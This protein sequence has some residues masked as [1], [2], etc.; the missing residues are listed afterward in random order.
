[1]STSKEQLDKPLIS[2]TD[3]VKVGEIKDLF[4]DTDIS[5]VIAVYLGQ[6][7]NL[8]NKTDQGLERSYIQ[9]YGIDSW[10]IAG[11][12]KVRELSEI[13]GSEE[14]VQISEIRGRE[15]RSEGNTPLGIIDDVLLDK[16][17][18]VIGFSLSKVFVK[19]PLSERNAIAREAI[20]NFGS[21]DIPM[22]TLLTKA[23]LIEI[24]A[25]SIY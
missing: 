24:S 20:T 1:M 25:L 9:V 19:G 22:K 4:V 10:L 5:K 7:G 23:E 13:A 21:K 16:E 6:E 18:N 3:G 17:A 15:I 11:S 12:D 8:F 2:I 14:F